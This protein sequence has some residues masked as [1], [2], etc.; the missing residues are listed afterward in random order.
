MKDSKVDNDEF[1]NFKLFFH[2]SY[3]ADDQVKD[4]A[5]TYK[6]RWCPKPVCVNGS[7]DS[8]LKTHRDGAINRNSLHKACSG[9]GKAIIEGANLPISSD[10]KAAAKEKPA[11]PSGTLTTYITKGKFDNH[12]MNKILLFW[13]I[14]QSL[15]WS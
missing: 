8:N 2:T 10:N 6:C 3:K 5:L 7:T 12:T 4:G 14:R 1:D 11:T 9:R 15:P 13:I